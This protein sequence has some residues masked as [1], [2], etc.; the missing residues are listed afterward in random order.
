MREG[1]KG[2]SGREGGALPGTAPARATEESG[3]SIPS[4]LRS[5]TGWGEAERPTP[6]GR[7]RAEVRTVNHRFLNLQLRTPSGF[8]RFQPALERS[9]REVFTRGH[10]SLS[11]SMDRGDL[12]E[13]EATPPLEVDLERARAYRDALLR[14]G[15]ELGLEGTPELH[16]FL[17]FRDLFV[18]P[19][20]ERALPEVEEEVV[21][22]V[23]TAAARGALAMRASEGRRLAD[24]LLGRLRLMEAEVVEIEAAAP[25]RLERERDRLLEAVG[26]LLPEGVPVD[27]DRVAREIA[28]LAERWDIHEE[29]VRFRSHLTMFRDTIRDGSADGVGKRLGFIV[30]E[31]LREA[32]TMGSKAND[33][34][35]AR[36][37]VALKEEIE[38]L[39]EQLENLE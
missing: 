32:N 9:L 33:A 14:M 20:R 21:V 16:H 24:D 15:S 10:V 7:L 37:V 29:V 11:V 28:H 38:R 19:E 6:S 8:E 4:G 2:P 1:T 3:E 25:G 39:R 23:V 26:R 22:E 18:V 36:S 34:G 30:Q 13:E 27:P 5:M 17:G 35:I 31:I 12:P